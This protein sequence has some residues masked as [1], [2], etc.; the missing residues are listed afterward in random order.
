VNQ[1]IA[2]A[3]LAGIT[4]SLAKV[5][6]VIHRREKALE[7]R[8]EAFVHPTQRAVNVNLPEGK[9]LNLAYLKKSTP[10]DAALTVWLS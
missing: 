7:Q 4:A 5:V 3:F 1:S 6:R 2:I 9:A 10:S 8:F